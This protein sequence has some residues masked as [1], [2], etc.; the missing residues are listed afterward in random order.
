MW[1]NLVLDYLLPSTPAH[2]YILS[3]GTLKLVFI[4]AFLLSGMAPYH[5]QAQISTSWG[6]CIFNASDLNLC[7]LTQISS[8]NLNSRM[9]NFHLLIYILT[10]SLP[11]MVWQHNTNHP[12]TKERQDSSCLPVPET[13][14][15]SCSDVASNLKCSKGIFRLPAYLWS[16]CHAI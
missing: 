4:L 7:V 13:W 9:C 5:F 14:K 2:K 12:K 11:F 15:L 6:S 8:L 10:W 3:S 1:Q 16:N